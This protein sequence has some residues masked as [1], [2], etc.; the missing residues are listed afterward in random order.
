[1]P[2]NPSRRLFIISAGSFAG[3]TGLGLA[4]TMPDMPPGHRTIMMLN[5]ACSD[6]QNINVFEPPILHVALGD[7]VTFLPTD[8]G[9][10]AASR[11]GMIPEGAEPWNGG[12]DEELT[13]E[14]SVPGIYGYVCTP[15]YEVGMAG[16]IVV[17]NELSNLDA[18]RAVRQRG[19]AR[20]AFRA[21][22]EE[23]EAG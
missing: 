17:G 21:L 9:H 12:V 23:L 15:H 19:R 6:D 18:A 10:N 22:F 14:M 2:T 13:L 11:R 5:A 8:A 1:M 16:L 3:V 4:N 7:V 20:T